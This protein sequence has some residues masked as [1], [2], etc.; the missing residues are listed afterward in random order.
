MTSSTRVATRLAF[1]FG[2]LALIRIVFQT[3]ILALNAAVK[4]ATASEQRRG[5]KRCCR[6]GRLT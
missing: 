4:A 1:G 6:R 3:N 2:V 5:C